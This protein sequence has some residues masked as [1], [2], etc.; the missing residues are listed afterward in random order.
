VPYGKY[1][2]FKTI[3]VFKTVSGEIF[4]MPVHE[5]RFLKLERADNRRSG[6]SAGFIRA[7]AAGTVS[8]RPGPTI[9][10]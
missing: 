9:L 5:N 2:L 3:I 7:P 6:P 4:R 1:L 8:A 10:E